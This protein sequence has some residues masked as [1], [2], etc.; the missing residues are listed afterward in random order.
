MRL[1]TLAGRLF[2]LT[3]LWAILAIALVGYL[4]SENYRR[5]AEQSLSSRLQANLYNIMGS[6]ELSE[7]GSLSGTP[8]LRDSRY[9]GF[10]SG[11]YWSVT[12]VGG[13]AS[14]LRSN[15]LAGEDITIAASIPFDATFQRRFETFDTAGNSLLGIEAQAF[16]GQGDDLVSFRIT[17]NRGEVDEEVRDFTR[18]LVL[19]L[20]L[21]TLGLLLFTIFVVRFALRPLREASQRLADIRDGKA[22][23]IDG[24]FPLEIQPL[25]DETNALIEANNRVIERARTQVG[26]LAHSLK[27]PLAVLRNEAAHV[28]PGL[29]GIIREQVSRMQVQVQT[30]LDRARISARTGIVTSRTDVGRSLE[31]LARVM[32]KLNPHLEISGPAP[33]APVMAGVETQDFD[34]IIGNLLENACKFGRNMVSLSVDAVGREVCIAIE[35][36]GPGMTEAEMEEALKR[37]A[38]LDESKPGSG[39]GLSIVADLVREYG[40]RLTLSP[41][42]LGGLKAEIRLPEAK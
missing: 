40:G 25:I 18:N 36:D 12:R 31:R 14:A 32:A 6:V 20:A 19:M 22:S 7:D 26:N 42:A 13:P 2:V 28:E 9:T 17:A 34:E 41:S 35:D 21:F 39:L 30:Y 27:T 3:S 1:R 29:A 10:R 23:H 33:S 5:N 38:R 24:T 11:Y 15:S 37:G 16:I 4:V 8:D